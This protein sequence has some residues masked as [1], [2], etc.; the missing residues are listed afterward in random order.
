MRVWIDGTHH[1]A[2]VYDRTTLLAGH[3]FFGP[4]IV[5]QA[6]CTTCLLPGA[7]AHIDSFGNLVVAL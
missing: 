1:D 7:A 3:S 6:D 4:A 5:E 2:A